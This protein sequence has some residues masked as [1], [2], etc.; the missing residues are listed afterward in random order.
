MDTDFKMVGTGEISHGGTGWACTCRWSWKIH[1]E[2][3]PEH[4][5][6][7][8]KEATDEPKTRAG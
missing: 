4:G 8:H 6:K 2:Y 7:G 5:I 3:C 1:G